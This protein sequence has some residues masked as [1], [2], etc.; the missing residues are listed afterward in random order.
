[1][2]PT[3]APTLLDGTEEDC[4]TAL[5][6][7]FDRLSMATT[8]ATSLLQMA[9]LGVAR[10]D[11][12]DDLRN[13]LAVHGHLL[14]QFLVKIRNAGGAEQYVTLA[15]TSYGAYSQAAAAQGDNPCAISVRA[16]SAAEASSL[17]VAHKALNI[18]G[19]LDAALQHP[20]LSVVVRTVARKLRAAP[21]PSTDFKR[22]AAND[23]D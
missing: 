10:G 18:A 17:A 9:A 23:R 14:Q 15:E 16:T 20:S 11:T 13:A 8:N 5:V 1:M 12:T 3:P 4:L 19:T 6:V 21:P 2:T 7:S 22:R